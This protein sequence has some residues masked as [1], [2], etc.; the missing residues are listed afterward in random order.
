MTDSV[1]ASIQ[2]SKMI[3]K[4]V[5]PPTTK[6]MS[7]AVDSPTPD[8]KYDKNQS[9]LMLTRAGKFLFAGDDPGTRDIASITYCLNEADRMAYPKAMHV[10]QKN[11]KKTREL[12]WSL[13]GTKYRTKSDM[14]SM[15]R[16]QK[17]RGDFR[18]WRFS[19][20][21]NHGHGNGFIAVFSRTNCAASPARSITDVVDNRQTFYY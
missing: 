10:G 19:Q 1:F 14:A 7:I 11:P 12:R 21:H 20:G 18:S 8:D 6:K 9:S 16:T 15:P 5:L 13:S 4:K 2:Y 3:Q 17:R